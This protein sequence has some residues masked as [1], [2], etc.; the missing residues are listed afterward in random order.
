MC[1][2]V[3]STGCCHRAQCQRT[4][5]PLNWIPFFIPIPSVIRKVGA[6]SQNKCNGEERR[7]RFLP[8]SLW[9]FHILQQPRLFCIKIKSISVQICN[10]APASDTYLQWKSADSCLMMSE[11]KK[12]PVC[13]LSWAV[14]HPQSACFH[15]K[16]T[17][18]VR[19]EMWRTYKPGA[20]WSY[21]SPLTP[22][23]TIAPLINN[24]TLINGNGKY[25]KTNLVEA[26]GVTVSSSV[27][28]Q[29]EFRHN[30]SSV[31]FPCGS[32]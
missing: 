5:L 23:I 29:Q 9:I 28:I 17:K 1:R 3:R 24:C 21:L 31:L 8:A 14:C 18:Y 15:A 19:W 6:T 12:L 27:Q 22:V 4:Y 13:H 7:R 20:V 2:R 30:V 16:I 11:E 26:I 32:F 10:S 25:T